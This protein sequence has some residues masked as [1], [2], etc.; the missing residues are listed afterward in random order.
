MILPADKGNATVVMKTEDY[1]KKIQELLDPAEYKKLN[2][3][4]TNKTLRKTNQLIE[5]SRIPS[6][7]QREICKTDAFPPRL[8]GLP[9]IQKDSV[10]LWPTVSSIGS[11]TYSIAKYLVILLQ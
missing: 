10:P 8:Y 2:R 3:D 1:D 4:P 5:L 7:R 11:P 6:E 9:K